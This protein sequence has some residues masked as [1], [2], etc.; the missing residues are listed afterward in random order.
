MHTK[1]PTTAEELLTEPTTAQA[2]PT[3]I[4]YAKEPTTAEKL[5]I[6]ILY[7]KESITAEKKSYQNPRQQ[8][9]FLSKFC[10]LKNLSQQ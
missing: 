6:K 1:E 9:K 4:L 3:K 7:A 2:L 5:C 8:E 10:T